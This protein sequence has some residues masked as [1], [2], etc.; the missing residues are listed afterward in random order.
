VSL[1]SATRLAAEIDPLAQSVL[2]TAG[3]HVVWAWELQRARC[4]GVPTREADLALVRA[5]AAAMVDESA[6]MAYEAEGLRV[7][8]GDTHRRMGLHDW[9]DDPVRPMPRLGEEVD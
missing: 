6:V 2:L 5:A 4:R 9:S 1:R 3:I 8:D 7:V